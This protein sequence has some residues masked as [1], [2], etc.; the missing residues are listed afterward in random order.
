MKYRRK[1]AKF[2]VYDATRYH[3]TVNKK[4]VIKKSINLE[5]KEFY[6]TYRE[7]AEKESK[8]RRRLRRY[9]DF[10]PYIA[11]TS[12]NLIDTKVYF[13]MKD[14]RRIEKAFKSGLHETKTRPKYNL[15]TLPNSGNNWFDDRRYVENKKWYGFRGT[16]IFYYY[17]K[18]MAA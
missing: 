5:G 2:A 6:K 8:S 11:K 14:D 9:A 17:K 18:R 12:K 15:L 1:Q 16:N 10:K 13:K 4:R 7:L 3:D